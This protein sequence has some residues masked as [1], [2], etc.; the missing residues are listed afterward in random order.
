MDFNEST[1]AIDGPSGSGKS[2]LSYALSEKLGLDVLET[3]TL[4]RC[5]T[6]LCLENDVDVN[7]ESEVL[8]QAEQMKYEFNNRVVLLNSQDVSKR[9]REHDVV[10]NVSQV[11]VHGK[12]RALLTQLMQDWLNA[13]KGGILEGRDITTVV[14]PKAKVRIYLDAPQEVRIDRRSEDINDSA[15]S[16]SIEEVKDTI[17]LRDQIDSNRKV[18]PLTKADGVLELDS[19]ENT[20]EELVDFIVEEYKK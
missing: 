10:S 17:A 14:A 18:N 11:S 7:D 1:I 3:G 13:H 4:Y 16:K 8:D 15:S 20:L 6:L 5:V 19:H 9:I 12:V 2:T